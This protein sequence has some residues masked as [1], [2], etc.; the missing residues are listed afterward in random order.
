MTLLLFLIMYESVL[1]MPDVEQA[2]RMSKASCS[3][4]G[5]L[6]LNSNLTKSTNGLQTVVGVNWF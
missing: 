2:L 5:K 1:S 6:I 4:A 3:V